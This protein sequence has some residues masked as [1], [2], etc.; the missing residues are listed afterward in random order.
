[1]K[2]QKPTQQETIIVHPICSGTTFHAS[3]QHPSVQLLIHHTIKLIICDF[4]IMHFIAHTSLN[5]IRAEYPSCL[6][7]TLATFSIILARLKV[8]V[9][10]TFSIGENTLESSSKAVL[11]IVG[12]LHYFIK[13]KVAKYTKEL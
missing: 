12:F 7:A 3:P 10:F 2:Q 1:M 4:I 13:V 11:S 9:L 8:I 5:K 6:R